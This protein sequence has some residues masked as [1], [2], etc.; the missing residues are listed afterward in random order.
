MPRWYRR[1][2]TA[3]LYRI[4]KRTPPIAWV[5]MFLI[6]CMSLPATLAIQIIHPGTVSTFREAWT[7]AQQHPLNGFIFASIV[8]AYGRFLM[9]FADGAFVFLRVAAGYNVSRNESIAKWV[10]NKSKKFRDK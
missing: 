3:N 7:I 5:A 1:Y 6:A 2:V 8:L 9:F 10:L 4:K